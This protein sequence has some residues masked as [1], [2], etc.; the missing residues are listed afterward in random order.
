MGNGVNNQPPSVGTIL[1]MAVTADLGGVHMSEVDFECYFHKNGCQGRGVLVPKSAMTYVGQDE[2]LALVDTKVI[3]AGEYM[4][5]F[6]AWIPDEDV[7][8]G[9]RQETV[10]VPTGVKVM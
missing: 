7:D 1:K 8:G 4:M 10:C 5:R 9:L 6:T 3:G 2:Y